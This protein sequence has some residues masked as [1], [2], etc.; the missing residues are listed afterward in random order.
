M[1]VSWQIM[2]HFEELYHFVRLSESCR[3]PIGFAGL[4]LQHVTDCMAEPLAISPPLYDTT[5]LN[6]ISAGGQ[7]QKGKKN[8]GG[9][10]HVQGAFL[11]RAP[12]L[13]CGFL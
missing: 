4:E 10:A 8:I 5:P 9:T 11:L 6:L 3:M 7:K 1:H 13:E 12:S 2:A